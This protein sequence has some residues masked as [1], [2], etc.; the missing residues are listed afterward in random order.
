M[1]AAT[2]APMIDRALAI[3]AEVTEAEWPQSA[4]AQA[5]I[6][7]KLG[8]LD[9]IL[10]ERDALPSRDP[11]SVLAPDMGPDWGLADALAY[12][13]DQALMCAQDARN[14]LGQFKAREDAG[15]LIEARNM[16]G[17]LL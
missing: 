16:T 12:L 7:F 8:Q 5:A 10:A 11:R 1:T 6:S 14:R 17:G 3:I 4:A 13:D 9:G 2:T 15:T